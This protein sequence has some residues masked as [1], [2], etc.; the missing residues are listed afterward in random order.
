M[1]IFFDY[2]MT[3]N[4]ATAKLDKD[5]YL[6]KGNR[7]IDYYFT[8]KDAAFRFSSKQD[9][10]IIE[11]VAP[12]HAMVSILKPDAT[13]V[14][15]GMAAI[16]DG[17]VKLTITEDIID[18]DTEVG[19]HCIVIDL[20]DDEKD[21]LVTLPP[22]LNQMHIL[23]RITPIPEVV[24]GSL[25][26]TSMVNYAQTTSDQD[27]E[28]VIFDDQG[29]YVKTDWISGNKITTQRLNKMEE[30][31]YQNNQSLKDIANELGKNEDD[32]FKELETT[33][34]T[35]IGAI[36]EVFQN[37]SNGK[38]LIANAI[39]GKG[40]AT[41]NT[42][43]FETMAI[44]IG[45]IE[46]GITP[47]GTIDITENGTVDVT[48][49]ASANVNIKT[50]IDVTIT[51]TSLGNKMYSF[52]VISDIHHGRS[53]YNVATDYTTALEILSTMNL[54]FVCSPGDLVVDTP[55]TR[56]PTFM[57]LWNTYMNIPL[58]ACTGNHDALV[59]ESVW[60]QYV[61]N[62]FRHSFEKDGDVFLFMSLDNDVTIT[63]TMSDYYSESLDWLS[64]KLTEYKGKRIFLF[65]H[66]PLYGYSGNKPNSGY[67]F[68]SSSTESSTIAGYLTSIENLIIFSGH[69]HYPFDAENNGT[70][71]NH[72]NFQELNYYNSATVHVP[73]LG[74][75]RLLT[76]SYM[77]DNNPIEGLI[78]DVYDS[79]I[80]I[81]GYD[82]TNN[83]Y[84][85]QYTYYMQVKNNNSIN[86]VVNT[87]SITLDES[88]YADF[89]VV[90]NRAI[91][92]NIT[93]NISNSNDYISLDKTSL[94]FTADNW[95]VAQTVRVTANH[96]EGNYDI[97]LSNVVLT[98]AEAN[99]KNITVTVNNIDTPPVTYYGI[100]KTLVGCTLS[101]SATQVEENTSYS[102]NI[103][104]EENYQIQSV[105]VKM[106]GT[107]I[108]SSA[109]NSGSNSISIASVT[110]NIEISI[111]AT[112]VEVEGTNILPVFASWTNDTKA[113]NT[114]SDSNSLSATLTLTA[115]GQ[116]LKYTIPA[117]TISANQGKT[118]VFRADSI[119]LNDGVAGVGIDLRRGVTDVVS[120]TTNAE[121]GSMEI[122]NTNDYII[123]IRAKS[124]ATGLPATLKI[125]NLRAYIK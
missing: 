21:S 37:A 30:G 72:I 5:I 70:T 23:E 47:S 123:R 115:T 26:N 101:N 46:T 80:A 13:V 102:T 19:T 55:D 34:K 116:G 50:N 125:T 71:Y 60:E 6:Y 111:T 12:S 49:Y 122:T 117:D 82:F 20:L 27:E 41:S 48:N 39:T 31:I 86:L 78:V 77:T 68:T 2:V 18:E 33:D 124:S 79:G 95:N 85:E 9:G 64:Q 66:F 43:S 103:N 58:Y 121:I 22:I 90:L 75:P 38:T 84:M 32:S 67:G 14:T 65:M 51:D 83:E 45:T 44:N 108:T 104:L 112:Y 35:I 99:T 118:L 87:E 52:G 7:N 120:M 105:S 91:E 56:V 24:S 106:G 1:A 119:T 62:G 109:Y 59:T 98:C 110:G 11:R 29:N 94:T 114:I 92:S 74:L 10:N 17:K 97:L 3:V 16:E 28:I 63:G 25:V 54:D 42:D 93:V 113:P 88:A 100:G 40:V 53:D 4:G 15:A 89:T 96:L 76:G 57:N 36:N 107:D 69:S 81:R 73:S 61:G 8:I